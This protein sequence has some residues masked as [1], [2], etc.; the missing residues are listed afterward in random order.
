M[1]LYKTFATAPKTGGK[2]GSPKPVGSIL[3][4]TKLTSIFLGASF[5]LI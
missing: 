2:G 3:F 5:I 1:F 4:S